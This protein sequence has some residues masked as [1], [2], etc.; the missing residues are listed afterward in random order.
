MRGRKHGELEDRRRV[1]RGNSGVRKRSECAY[2][3]CVCVCSRLHVQI[4]D[5]FIETAKNDSADL[6]LLNWKDAHAEF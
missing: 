2:Y 1:A 4:I 6:H 3:L 5:I